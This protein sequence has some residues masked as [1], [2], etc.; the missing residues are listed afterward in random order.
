[1]FQLSVFVFLLPLLCVSE[2]PTI[3]I[4]LGFQDRIRESSCFKQ[5]TFISYSSEVWGVQNQGAA[6]SVPHEIPLPG[7]QMARFSPCPHTASCRGVDSGRW[8]RDTDLPLP[9]PRRHQS[10]QEGPFLRAHLP[11]TACQRGHLQILAQ[12]GGQSLKRWIL[13]GHIHSL[14]AVNNP[15]LAPSQTRRAGF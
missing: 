1:M 7:L 4:S 15:P 11:L 3:S 12:C 10:P 14:T 5:Q 8:G 9:L 6:W 13:R 2:K